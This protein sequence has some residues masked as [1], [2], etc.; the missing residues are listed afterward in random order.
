MESAWHVSFDCS[1]GSSPGDH[2]FSSCRNSQGINKRKIHYIHY[3]ISNIVNCTKPFMCKNYVPVTPLVLLGI[4]NLYESGLGEARARIAA[5]SAS[6]AA[7]SAD[8]RLAQA[9]YMW[10]P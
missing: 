8:R 6:R 10:T 4:C 2:N 1:S 9:C 3:S 7:C 5:V